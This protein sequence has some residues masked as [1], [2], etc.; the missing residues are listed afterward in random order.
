VRKFRF[1]SLKYFVRDGVWA[2]V[3]EGTADTHFGAFAVALGASASR[4]A[5]LASAQQL[6]VCAL[7]L[8]GE[9]LTTLAGGRKRFVLACVAA[10]V[11]CLGAM[12][13]GALAGWGLGGFFALTVAYFAAGGV[14]GPAW[15]AWVGE[16]LP[17]RKRGACFSVR[18][19][20]VYP[21]SFLSIVL[22]G[23]WLER[24]GADAG[25]SRL[26]ASGVS[27]TGLAFFVVFAVAA[28][29][30]LASLRQLLLQQGGEPIAAAHTGPFA[31]LAGLSDPDQARAMGFFTA[32]S[33]A[34][35][36]SSP[37]ASPYLLE[38]LKVGYGK[39][40]AVNAA[41]VA[42]RF[43]SAPLVGRI[44]DREGSRKLL[45]LSSLCL[46]I[47]PLGWALAPN[48][49]ALVAI[50]LCSGVFWTAYDM[51]S[52]TYL[53]ESVP[54]AERHR[55]FALQ[56]LGTGIGA[57]GGAAAG[58]ALA[59]GPGGAVA[60]FWASAVLR[61]GAAWLAPRDELAPSTIARR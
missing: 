30:R 54:A 52:F 56:R 14:S 25:P 33:F 10:Q 1:K 3:C 39:F 28:A 9:R 42:A 50:Q 46:P 35:N 19:R 61:A 26:L 58:A 13:A 12:A 15:S 40:A 23:L 17:S 47:V 32:M 18:N 51:C 21:A 2:S 43:L 53:V 24:A 5:W 22:T 59:F 34:V 36:V 60:A 44:I 49:V 7:Q 11:A 6:A 37:I 38:T 27:R 45:A 41:L 29:A 20:W 48:W 4:I 31:Q 57:V 8:W 55:C 16:L